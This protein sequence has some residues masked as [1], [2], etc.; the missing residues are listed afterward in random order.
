MLFS[1]D[2]HQ[3]YY[4][5]LFSQQHICNAFTGFGLVLFDDMTI[6]TLGGGNAGVAQLLGHSDDVG[7][8]GQKD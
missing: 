4:S 1:E 8:V 2:Q 7:S 5:C 6:E 3:G